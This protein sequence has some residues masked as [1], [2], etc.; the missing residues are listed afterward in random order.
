[1]SSQNEKVAP[2][3]TPSLP[4][5]AVNQRA[6]HLLNSSQS[7]FLICFMD[8]MDIDVINGKCSASLVVERKLI[9][10]TYYPSTSKSYLKTR[11]LSPRQ[12]S[13]SNTTSF[14]QKYQ[15][16]QRSLCAFSTI[17]PA[18]GASP[19]YHSNYCEVI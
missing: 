19:L 13:M 11:L 5:E 1:M 14:C 15:F 8:G 10:F 12:L 18:W 3:A 7:C 2:E 16:H 4:P 9:D 6:P 17:C